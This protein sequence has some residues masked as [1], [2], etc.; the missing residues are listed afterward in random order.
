MTVLSGL[1]TIK[2]G[3]RQP[4]ARLWRDDAEILVA[5]MSNYFFTQLAGCFD[6]PASYTTIDIE[7]S[8]LDWDRN[9][10]CSIGHTKVRGGEAVENKEHYL[11]WTTH[12]EVDQ[13]QFR[14]QLSDTEH[15]MVGQGK[16]FHHNYDVL[17]QYGEDPVQ[18]LKDYLDMIEDCERRQEV[19]VLHNGWGFDIPYLSASFEKW[20][21]VY[22]D[23]PANGVYDTG[24]VEK[25]SQLEARYEPL[26]KEGE[27]LRDFS[28]RIRDIRAKGVRW[29]LDGHCENK[30]GLFG[31]CGIK[32]EEAHRSAVDSYI[33]H[34]LFEEHRRLAGIAASSR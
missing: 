20:L 16:P 32:M 19:M 29:A 1:P 21:S 9:F 22:Y 24:C 28:L 15:Y 14:K 26:P 18:V 2:L 25:A 31:R 27:N 33:T 5:L 4:P 7:T 34:I 8:G 11:N 12:P 10:I 13:F 23:F 17:A 3:I 6:F 30:Y